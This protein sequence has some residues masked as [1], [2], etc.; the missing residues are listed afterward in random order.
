MHEQ[1]FTH[2]RTNHNI[3]LLFQKLWVSSS[4]FQK[5]VMWRIATKRWLTHRTK[6]QAC[7]VMEQLKILRAVFYFSLSYLRKLEDTDIALHKEEEWH[8]TNYHARKVLLMSGLKLNLVDMHF[9]WSPLVKVLEAD[10][11][12]ALETIL[13][14]ISKILWPVYP[15]LG[16]GLVNTFPWSQHA[17]EWD[18]CH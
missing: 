8:Q 1:Q 13:L 17:Q 16:S 10:K 11:Y 7:K 4:L 18:S 15:F 12:H 9:T 14:S 6:K 3:R 2:I 5:A